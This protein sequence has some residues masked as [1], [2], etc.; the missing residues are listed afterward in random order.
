MEPQGVGLRHGQG[1]GVRV[2]LRDD[3]G[4]GHIRVRGPRVRVDWDA[5][6]EQRHLQLRRAADGAHLRAQPR[7]LQ[8]PRRRGEPGGVVQ[9]HGGQ[10]PRRGPCGPAHRRAAAATGAQPGAPR[11][12]PLHRRRRAQ[13]AQ[14]GADRAHAR[15]RRVPLPHGIAFL[16]SVRSPVSLATSSE[17][18][19]GIGG[20]IDCLTHAR[21][22]LDLLFARCRSTARRGPL[23][24]RRRARGRRF[25]R[26][27]SVP[28]TTRTSR[29]GDEGSELQLQANPARTHRARRAR[30]WSWW[31][32]TDFL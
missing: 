8:P 22:F 19:H 28:P 32:W 1:A 12:P 7:G 6:R 4:D 20:G 16:C 2:Q 21:P 13:A 3:P 23:T 26:R 5:E 31:W 24:G 14:D 10:P 18:A 29:C 25:C 17:L 30:S 9:G 15:G 11:L 27:T